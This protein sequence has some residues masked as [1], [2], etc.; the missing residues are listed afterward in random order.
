MAEQD[1]IASA[2][3]GT[4]QVPA[5]MSAEE[6]DNFEE[7]SECQSLPPLFHMPNTDWMLS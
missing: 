7:V 3:S 6:A 2:M 5:G 4:Q 1:L